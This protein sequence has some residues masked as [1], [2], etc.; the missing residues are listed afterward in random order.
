MVSLVHTYTLSLTRIICKMDL[1]KLITTKY[2]GV[3]P[4]AVYIHYM[5]KYDSQ[6]KDPQRDVNYIPIDRS[7]LVDKIEEY[8][9]V[10]CTAKEIINRKYSVWGVA[11]L[12]GS[13]KYVNKSK[14]KPLKTA[15]EKKES[16]IL[17]VLWHSGDFKAWNSMK[18][19]ARTELTHK[20]QQREEAG[21]LVMLGSLESVRYSRTREQFLADKKEW[22]R[23]NVGSVTPGPRRQILPFDY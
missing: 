21:A 16:E 18:T 1:R 14:C 10:V 11:Y 9:V 13:N 15:G 6:W 7:M 20:D 2:P 17:D 23:L 8:V 12:R 3:K 22:Y 19:K 4:D 5:S